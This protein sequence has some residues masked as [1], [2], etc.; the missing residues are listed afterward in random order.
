M[1]RHIHERVQRGLQFSHPNLNDFF[2][3]LEKQFE[4]EFINFFEELG[5]QASIKSD[6]YSLPYNEE[7]IIKCMRESYI[8]NMYDRRRLLRPIVK[9]LL[10]KN[11]NK[12]RF[13]LHIETYDD[14]FTKGFQVITG[15]GF[16]YSFRYYIHN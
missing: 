4:E 2:D 8:N 16:K 7:I 3:K 13:Y 15:T 14:G 6:K 1:E 12:I 10:S 5:I 9:E 11:I